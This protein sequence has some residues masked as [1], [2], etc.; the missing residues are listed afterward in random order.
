[1]YDDLEFLVGMWGENWYRVSRWLRLIVGRKWSRQ[2][3]LFDV[4]SS[5]GSVQG[6]GLLIWL[7]G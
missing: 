6:V 3:S 2:G 5:M 1:M 7:V 4:K